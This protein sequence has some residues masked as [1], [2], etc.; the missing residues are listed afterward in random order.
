M[1]GRRFQRLIL[2]RG[3]KAPRVSNLSIGG[4]TP[5]EAGPFGLE[6]AR[7]STCQ[8]DGFDTPVF[9]VVFTWVSRLSIDRLTPPVRSLPGG[10]SPRVSNLSIDAWRV[11][12]CQ[13][14][15][16]FWRGARHA[17]GG[18]SAP[19]LQAGP[20]R[21]GWSPPRLDTLWEPS[22]TDSGTC[23]ESSSGDD[24]NPSLSAISGNWKAGDGDG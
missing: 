24:G 15:N 20:R 8:F 18:R 23:S 1:S 4:L 13:H 10:A 6:C 22:Q 3:W 21:G 14:I 2:D 16:I 19:A 11:P 12:S 5:L 9:G 7:V 17:G